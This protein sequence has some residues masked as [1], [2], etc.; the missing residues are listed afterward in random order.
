MFPGLERPTR[1]SKTRISKLS[2]SCIKWI[3]SPCGMCCCSCWS[4]S[5]TS[6]KQTEKML[7]PRATACE[8]WFMQPA[9]RRPTGFAIWPA[10]RW[11][12]RPSGARW[13]F[14]TNF[15]GTVPRPTGAWNRRS[16]SKPSQFCSAFGVWGARSA[17]VGGYVHRRTALKQRLHMMRF[18]FTWALLKWNVFSFSWDVFE[19]L[20]WLVCGKLKHNH[21]LNLVLGSWHEIVGGSETPLHEAFDSLAEFLKEGKIDFLQ[22]AESLL[23]VA[24]ESRYRIVAVVGLFDKGPPPWWKL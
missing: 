18:W 19:R 10:L 20:V 24:K 17:N 1:K 22:K 8:H 23:E 2:S 3:G 14:T 21:Q 16:L 15:R 13:W 9:I 11:R 5:L 4:L 7:K 12:Y 6:N